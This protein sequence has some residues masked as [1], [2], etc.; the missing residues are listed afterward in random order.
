M[1]I[2]DLYF[3]AAELE[4]V[5]QEVILSLP[6]IGLSLVNNFTRKEISYIGITRLEHSPFT[7]S[8]LSC[9]F[10]SSPLP[11]PL[12]YYHPLLSNHCYSDYILLTRGA[13][14]CDVAIILWIPVV[15]GILFLCSVYQMFCIIVFIIN[16]LFEFQSRCAKC[17]HKVFPMSLVF[18]SGYLW[19]VVNPSSR[20]MTTNELCHNPYPLIC[21]PGELAIFLI[22]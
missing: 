15:G 10:L 22:P 3:Q 9:H 5:D 1:Q 21:L 13:V 7:T 8:L 12:K 17:K 6:G 11:S 16:K 19:S 14:L 18:K 20:N 2:Y 4:Q